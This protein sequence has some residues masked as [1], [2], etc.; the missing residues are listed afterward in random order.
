MDNSAKELIY[1]TLLDVDSGELSPEEAQNEIIT[2]ME[3]ASQFEWAEDSKIYAGEYMKECELG[4]Y[5]VFW[6]G[7]GSSIASIGM[8]DNG[9]RWVAPTN[10]SSKKGSDPTGNLDGAERIELLYHRKPK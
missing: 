5:E 8:R 3:T 10:W 4:I 6:K 9:E 7:G 2:L 1:R